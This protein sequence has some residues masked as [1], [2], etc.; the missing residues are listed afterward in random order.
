MDDH[1]MSEETNESTR[2]DFTNL[3]Y[4]QTPLDYNTDPNIS[5]YEEQPST[6]DEPVLSTIFRDAIAISQKLS[7]V[8]TFKHDK[9]LLMD[10]DLWGPMILFMVIAGV[11]QSYVPASTVLGSRSPFSQYLF[12]FCVSS[13]LLAANSKLLSLKMSSL[14]F[15]CLI[16]YCVVPLGI[17]AI[18]SFCFSYMSQ[19]ILFKLIC[20]LLTISGLTMSILASFIF[21]KQLHPREKLILVVFPVF[22]FYFIVAWFLIKHYY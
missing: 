1:S 4:T 21:M 12:F 3:Q 2:L 17:S 19:T 5:S 7:C 14:Q 6:L 16:G 22:L 10:W 11:I 20:I 15:I 13:I 18:L 8:L 9:R